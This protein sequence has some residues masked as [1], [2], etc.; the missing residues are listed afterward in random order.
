MTSCLAGSCPAG[1]SLSKVAQRLRDVAEPAGRTESH[2]SWKSLKAF[3]IT[4][5]CFRRFICRVTDVL[6]PCTKLL[7]A[8]IL[9]ACVF[10]AHAQ[11]SVIDR[12]RYLTEE[13]A[14]CQECHTRRLASGE[15]DRSSWLKGAKLNFAPESGGRSSITAPDITSGG[16]LWRQWS[17]KGMLRYL[18]TG[19]DPAGRIASPPMPPYRLR[20]DDAEA[21]V[22]YLATLR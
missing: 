11:K 13:V 14:Q 8:A 9:V 1:C 3:A 22:K 18:E 12:G 16:T 15:F 17:E 4:E 5:G 2:P 7:R 19:R 20:P 21:I 10:P 6:S